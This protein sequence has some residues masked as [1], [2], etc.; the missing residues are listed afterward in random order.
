M[1]SQSRERSH[2]GGVGRAVLAALLV[3]PSTAW[4]QADTEPPLPNVMLLIDTSGSMEYMAEPD[5]ITKKPRLPNCAKPSPA[6]SQTYSIDP[7]VT[8]EQNRWAN[9]VTVLTGEIPQ[10]A[11]VA[12]SRSTSLFSSEF[13]INSS[14]PYDQ[15]YYLPYN[16][17]VSTNGT[18]Q[19]VVGPN[20]AVWP[21][22]NLYGYPADA[23]RTHRVGNNSQ[24]CTKINGAFRLLQTDDGLLDVFRDRAR[25]GLMTF[26]SLPSKE[27]G[28]N[29]NSIDAAKGIQ[30]HWSYFPGWDSGGGGHAKGKPE[31]CATDQEIEVGVRNPAAPPWE[32]RLIGFG[33]PAASA[34][35]VAQRN[36]QIQQAIMAVRPYGAT[37]LAGMLSDAEHFFFQDNT[38]DKSVTG[39]VALGPMNDPYVL[40]GCRQQFVILLTDG[41]PNLDLRPGCRNNNP[42]PPDGT[43]PFSEPSAVAKRLYSQYPNKQVRTFVVGFAVSSADTGG[44]INLD[45]KGLTGQNDAVCIN[46]ATE[47]VRA[48]CEMAKIAYEGGTGKPRFAD[49]KQELR[50]ALNDIL[51]EVSQSTT[52]RT[53]PVFASAGSAG[54]G[55]S[56]GSGVAAYNILTSFKVSTGGL[57]RGVLERQR[58]TCDKDSGVYT[59]VPQ[60]ISEDQGDR[61]AV[62]MTLNQSSRRFITVVP[63]VISKQ[64]DAEHSVRRLGTIADGIGN[65]SA[66]QIN[67][68]QGDFYSSNI[69][70]AMELAVGNAAQSVCGTIKTPVSVNDCRNRIL[71]WYTGLPMVDGSLFDR[72]DSPMG[73]IF[74][75]TPVVVGPPSEFLRDESYSAF[76][77]KYKNRAPVVYTA[78]T[79]GQLHAFKLG[80]SSP[81]DTVKVDSKAVNNELWSF[82][83]PAVL[84]DLKTIYPGVERRLLDVPIFARDVVFERKREDSING[85]G[86][87][88]D[89]RSVLVTGLGPSRGG[90]F[91]MDVTTPEFKPPDSN[92]P[93]MLWQITSDGS[94]NPLFGASVSPVITTIFVRTPNMPEAREVAVAILPGGTSAPPANSTPVNRAQA[95][96]GTADGK[97]AFRPKVRSYSEDDPSRSLTI[98]RLD[99]GEVIRRFHRCKSNNAP[100]RPYSA[101]LVSRSTCT[102]FDSPITSV[103]LPFPNGT[104]QSS[105]RVFVGDQDGALWRVDLS[106]PDPTQWKVDPFFDAYSPY[107]NDPNIGQPILSQPVASLD[108]LGNLVVAFATGDQD[109]FNGTLGMRNVLWSVSE[110][111]DLVAGKVGSRANWH[112]GL[113]NNETVSASPAGSAN[114][115]WANGIRVAGPLSLFGGAVYFSTYRPPLPGGAACDPGSSVLWA[116]DY[117][118]NTANSPNG[119]AGP[120]AALDLSG[121]LFHAKEYA[122][123]LI[124]GVGIQRLP[125]CYDTSTVDD[126]YIGFGTGSTAV[127]EM[128]RPEYKLVVQTGSKGVS[129]AQSETK[130][131]TL[132][133]RPPPSGALISSWASVVELEGST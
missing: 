38:P 27:V 66:L 20:P 24:V 82:I 129:N 8:Y 62:N 69:A 56:G 36:E 125:A 114:S 108:P 126:P 54:G 11:C 95:G 33:D 14:K 132:N 31:L 58:Y 105:T 28:I 51:S 112:L 88:N 42:G 97:W 34:L 65:L 57:W 127:S 39:Q 99:T 72:V 13:G 92:G 118:K 15:D 110:V 19:C 116:V 100:P 64:P 130:F 47:A 80:A 1:R 52:S 26:D 23:I 85:A 35:T 71:R 120:V 109:R 102:N 2:L 68:L 5:P 45:C 83:P 75:S 32:G 37:P 74:H 76:A 21:G 103:P 86:S 119:D 79:D 96:G 55:Y 49:N 104:G 77:D 98:V 94:G 70:G 63:D 117:L 16:R 113:G 107:P 90:Y 17:I 46:P 128:T 9:L 29:G 93:T 18:E 3:A 81:N 89:W 30:G 10:Y 91:A 101:A 48:C 124:F 4:A 78:T 22:S 121:Q 131:E 111:P 67:G 73:S 44:P 25:F 60:P 61:F 12:E 53:T 133:L 115:D 40:G 106:N 7:A 123:A 50:K 122:N 6:N 84:T 59:V 43:C 41:I 87:F